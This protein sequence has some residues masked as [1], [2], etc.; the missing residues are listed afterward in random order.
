MANYVWKNDGVECSLGDGN[1]G[2]ES[3]NFSLADL[4]CEEK[5]RADLTEILARPKME[6]VR[7]TLFHGIKQKSADSAN[8]TTAAEKFGVIKAEL[9]RLLNPFFGFNAVRGTGTGSAVPAACKEFGALISSQLQNAWKRA[10]KAIVMEIDSEKLDAFCTE[11]VFE[12]KPDNG[13][14]AP[15]KVMWRKAAEDVYADL[16]MADLSEFDGCKF[17]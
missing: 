7:L 16:L 11:K 13:E 17:D 5:D 2:G 10:K 4:A 3:F 9:E 6:K 12:A 15:T 8:T 1:E 14:K